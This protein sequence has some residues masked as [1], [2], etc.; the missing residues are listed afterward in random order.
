M[1]LK[2]RKIISKI[3]RIEID[4][5]KVNIEII[6]KD[7]YTLRIVIVERE[8]IKIKNKMIKVQKNKKITK[9]E[10]VIEEV[11]VGTIEE[12]VVIMM[13]ETTN[14]QQNIIIHHNLIRIKENIVMIIKREKEKKNVKKNEKE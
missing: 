13:I 4:L 14:H 5:L 9:V 10:I 8:I 2:N 6:I 11:V 7:L 1:M 3:K 12:K